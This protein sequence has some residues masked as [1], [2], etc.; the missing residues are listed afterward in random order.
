[1]K[2]NEN[3]NNGQEIEETK[4]SS[5]VVEN[6]KK[7]KKD[8]KENDKKNENA[9][10]R[11]KLNLTSGVVLVMVVAVVIIANLLV[12]A[13]G[14]RVPTKI[15]VTDSKMYSFTE[16]TMQVI[17]ALDKDVV[18]YS[19]IPEDS[20]AEDRT[21]IDALD[22]VD[23]TLARYDNASPK[24]K[25]KRVDAKKNP[26]YLHKYSD[27]DQPISHYSII[28][29]CGDR[30]RVI[31][32][33]AV[34]SLN[35]TTKK[36]QFFSVEQKVTMAIV[37]VARSNDVVVGFVNNH[38]AAITFDGFNEQVLKPEGY[39]AVAVD[40]MVGGVPENVDILM[41]VSPTIDFTAEEINQIDAYFDKGGKVQLVI[42]HFSGELPVLEE[43]LT[44]WGVTLY[45]GYV[46][47]TNAK[48]IYSSTPE[49]II[50]EVK[51]S[52]ATK[53]IIANNYRI[54]YPSARGIKLEAISGI[55]HEDLL[56][57]SED[58]FVYDAYDVVEGDTIADGP[59]IVSTIL[60]GLPTQEGVPAL[61]ITGGSG[62][63]AT[64]LG[65]DFFNSSVAYMTNNE[66]SIFIRPKDITPPVLLISMN[67]IIIITVVTVIVIPLLLLIIGFAVWFTRRRL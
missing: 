46:V 60:T 16:E 67:K 13:I 66:E 24:I 15:D 5:E 57:A 14:N 19:L 56:V 64:E 62:I 28:V 4:V 9:V 50:P 39:N 3:K 23:E 53:S 45:D 7:D 51:E 1:M 26:D 49:Y 2:D 52:P 10:K 6:D 12:V 11:A 54:V 27:N 21:V 33:N 44:E 58:S 29:E 59:V 34:I 18:I 65:F 63:F 48:N 25:Y 61:M 42:D 17:N 55:N 41:I 30:F 22:L 37:N 36:I 32:V 47:E 35:A 40:L 31:D 8:K 38:S 20:E 43:Y